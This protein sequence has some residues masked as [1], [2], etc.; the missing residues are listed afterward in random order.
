MTVIKTGHIIPQYN[1][2]NPLACIKKSS[3]EP[4]HTVRQ[5]LHHYEGHRCDVSRDGQWRDGT[6]YSGTMETRQEGKVKALKHCLYKQ[7]SYMLCAGKLVK[8][9]FRPV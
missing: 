4:S 5:N 1:V 7:S 2:G 8:T 6:Q 9:E 3:G